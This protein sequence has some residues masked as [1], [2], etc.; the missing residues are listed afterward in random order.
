MASISYGLVY[1]LVA[2]QLIV[3][4][5]AKEP[6]P[7]TWWAVALLLVGAAN[8][9]LTVVDVRVAAAVL[10]TFTLFGYLHYVTGVVQEI[11]QHLG[12]KCFVIAVHKE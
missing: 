4:H 2:S 5:M 10:M 11:C 1:A 6:V 12:I 9:Q 7:V 3:A 8:Q